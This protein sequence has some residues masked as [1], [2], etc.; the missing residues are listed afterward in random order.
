M[1]DGITGLV[2]RADSAEELIKAMRTLLLDPARTAEM[3]ASAR[4]FAEQG[5]E[6]ITDACGTILHPSAVNF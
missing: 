4:C 6:A 2:A 5:A 1:R 3:G